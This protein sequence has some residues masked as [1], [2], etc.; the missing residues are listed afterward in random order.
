MERL[1]IEFRCLAPGEAE[2]RPGKEPCLGRYS[3]LFDLRKEKLPSALVWSRE[4]RALS[5]TNR[6]RKEEEKRR[7]LQR[8]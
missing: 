2:P 4:G 7:S 1:L 6:Q 8:R 5:G 3:V